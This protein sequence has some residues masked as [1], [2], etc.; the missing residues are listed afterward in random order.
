MDWK[1]DKA[2]IVIP[3]IMGSNLKNSENNN[4]VW[5]TEKGPFGI[6]ELIYLL[7]GELHC[8]EEGESIKSIEPN[9]G[10]DEYGAK[11]SYK[12]L[13]TTLQKRVGESYKI[14][15]FAYDWRLDNSRNVIFLKELIDKFDKVIIIAHSMG[16]LIAA[17]YISEYGKTKIDK[18]ITLGTPYWGSID[19]VQ[20]L[21]N[22]KLNILSNDIEGIIEQASLSFI[23]KN[24]KEL[25]YNYPS[26]YQLIPNEE[27]TENKPWLLTTDEE[28]DHWYDYFWQ[29][30]E[31]KC[32]NVEK[33]KKFIET[34]SNS[35]LY[36]KALNFHKEIKDFFNYIEDLDYIVIVGIEINTIDAIKIIDRNNIMGTIKAVEPRYSKEGDGVVPFL[37]AV[38]NSKEND[39]VI[40]AYEVSHKDLIED[41]S[42]LDTIINF[43][44]AD[45]AIVNN[46]EREKEVIKKKN[47][48][49][50][51][52]GDVD[53]KIFSGRNEIYNVTKIIKEEFYGYRI[54]G[55][56]EFKVN[57]VGKIGA[58]AIFVGTG[59][60]QE[61]IIKIKSHKEQIVD[62]SIG[63]ERYLYK[64]DR[65]HLMHGS[66]LYVNV[67]YEE[68]VWLELDYN[69]DGKVDEV[70]R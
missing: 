69:G 27:F 61:L 8:N 56:E 37:S 7:N 18:L 20:C 13:I 14:Q 62:F 6:M 67:D 46:N 60:A 26:I 38:M 54:Y 15:F 9:N 50:V 28:L 40:K 5:I 41:D 29:D 63:N 16:G 2:I 19:A 44:N 33:T 51:F 52:A 11:D 42:I 17:K 43:I 25:L 55:Q 36:E 34:I 10:E 59:E 65:I 39:R 35:S 70:I 48:K 21:Y 49:F 1:M 3:G 45:K 57:I 22:G 58:Q 31:E 68:K 47:I 24:I 53:I 66:R 32:N 12:K 23:S 30:E 4:I 64:F